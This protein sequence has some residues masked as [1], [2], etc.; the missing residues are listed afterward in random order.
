MYIN[1]IKGKKAPMWFI[2]RGSQ[3]ALKNNGDHS[4]GKAKLQIREHS[5]QNENETGLRPTFHCRLAT[6]KAVEQAFLLWIRHSDLFTRFKV[7]GVGEK[8]VVCQISKNKMAIRWWPWG[9]HAR[10]PRAKGGEH[11][12]TSRSRA[13]S[14]MTSPFTEG[15]FASF[16]NA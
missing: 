15:V 9:P 11:V 7:S 3:R 13:L 2:E 1:M 5:P 14:A 16:S 4:K 6:R 8:G 10:P 12:A